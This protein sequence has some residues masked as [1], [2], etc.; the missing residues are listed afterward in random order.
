MEICKQQSDIVIAISIYGYVGGRHGYG[1]WSGCGNLFGSI[2]KYW[3]EQLKF[4]F[5]FGGLWALEWAWHTDK[6]NLRCAVISR[7]GM[8]NP[9]IA[10]FID[11][12][13]T[14]FIRTDGHI[15]FRGRKRFL[16]PVTYFPTNQYTLTIVFGLLIQ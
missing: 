15:Y 14:A 12:D 16:L 2:N 5:C 11:S 8:P 4:V 3:W 1:R 9:S 13:I 10:A 6:T 7:I